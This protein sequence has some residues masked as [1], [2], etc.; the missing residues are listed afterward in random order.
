[1]PA[2]VPPQT[3]LIVGGGQFGSCAAASLAQGSYKG[4]EHLITV[5]ERGAE[6]PAIDA[7]SSDYNK[8]VRSEYSD[9]VYAKLARDAIAEWETNPRWKPFY[10]G[11]GVIA[12]S[13]KSDPQTAYVQSAYNFN[14]RELG[15]D[16]CECREDG[17]MKT[18]YPSGVPTGSFEGTWGYKNKSGGWA[19]SRDA[20]VATNALARSLG[21]KYVV[22][23]ASHLIFNATQTDV[24]GV[25][26]VDGTAIKADFV[27]SAM[28]SWTPI[29]LPEL[30]EACLPTGQTVAAIQLT[31]EEQELYKDIPVSLCMDTGFYNFPPTASGLVK[32]AI[33]DR[34]WLSPDSQRN[35]PSSPRTSLTVG[36][37]NQQIPAS[38]LEA[39]KRGMSRIHPELAKK[40][41]IETRLCWY[42]DR[43][44]GDFLFDYH[45]RYRSLFVAAGGS[46]HAF[47]FMPLT[48]QWIVDSLDKRLPAELERLWSF[49]GDLTRLDK[50]R[51]E[52]PI[53]RKMLPPGPRQAKL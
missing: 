29:L 49:E 16:M 34:G 37:E 47:K 52:G 24:R 43:E 28:G 19:A 25:K 50:S 42:S 2:P 21:V 35:L 3:V 39:I 38:A 22:G 10:H 27:I 12:L 46:G 41:I 9:P 8:I 36:Y 7:A 23:E 45:P 44:S 18:L 48:G 11:C 31:K 4:H 6:P 14:T 53:V 1:M 32:L 26:L 30:K 40:E 20:V 5:I 17:E 33:H 51:G 13:S 15:K